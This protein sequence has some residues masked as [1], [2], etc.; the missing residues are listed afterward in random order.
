MKEKWMHYVGK[1]FT[2]YFLVTAITFFTSILIGVL[3]DKIL[4]ILGLQWRN[5][6]NM[7]LGFLWMGSGL[8][9]LVGI[10]I[11]LLRKTKGSWKIRLLAIIV[12]IVLIIGIMIVSLYVP[13]LLLF[14]NKPE[15]VVVWNGQKCV[16]SDVVWFD[17]TRNWYAYHGWFVMGRESL[18]YEVVSP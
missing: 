17:T 16:T 6:V 1:D 13:F 12:A 4:K 14:G 3:G 10:P 5:W 2:I 9:F 8:L 11:L 15:S 18:H 7:T